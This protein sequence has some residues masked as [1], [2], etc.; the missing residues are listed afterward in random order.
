MRQVVKSIILVVFVILLLTSLATAAE[1]KSIVTILSEDGRFTTLLAAME[2]TETTEAFSQ[3]NWTLFAPTDAAFAK[4]GVNADN[5][6]TTFGIQELADLL[7]YQTMHGRTT[8]DDAKKML[9][10]I[11]MA[12]DWVAGLKWFAGTLWVNDD[13]KAIERDISAANGVI[14]VIDTVI[15][16]PWP[17]GEADSDTALMQDLKQAA[18]EAEAAAAKAAAEAKS[19]A[20]SAADGTSTETGGG[21]ETSADAGDTTAAPEPVVVPANSLLGVANEDGRFTTLLAAIVA[22]DLTEPFTE[23]NWTLFAP[24]DDAFAKIGVNAANVASKYSV[25]ELADLL[26]YHAMDKTITADKAKTMLGDITM[27]NGRLAGL[28]Y[29]EGNLWVNDN[30]KVIVEDIQTGNGVIHVVDSVIQPPWPRVETTMPTT[31]EG[32]PQ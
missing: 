31:T 29:Y 7:L 22:L 23:G 19:E 20:E 32:D 9:G 26:L 28:K 18:A 14:H 13:S 27:R 1:E 16:P 2:T 11:T 24:T 4:L 25:G 12:N 6:A 5:V 10:D 30:A 21:G 3:G 15:T 17:R 8:T